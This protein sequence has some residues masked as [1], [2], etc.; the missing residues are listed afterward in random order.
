MNICTQHTHSFIATILTY[1]VFY[2][3]TKCI[4]TYTYI[5]VYTCTTVLP[6]YNKHI[7]MVASNTGQMSKLQL[8]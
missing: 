1:R 3:S 4:S 6:K 7:C 8:L 2:Q 5:H